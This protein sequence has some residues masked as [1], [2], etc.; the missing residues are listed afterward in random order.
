MCGIAGYLC[1]DPQQQ[2]SELL[3][4]RMALKLHHRGPDNQGSWASGPVALGHA[5]LSILD[6]RPEANQPMHHESGRFVVVFNGE[7]YNFQQLARSHGLQMRTRCDTEV[8]LKLYQRLGVDFL[9]ELRGMF[10]IALWDAERR[11]LLLARDRLGKKPLYYYLGSRG[12]SFASEVR[13]LLEDPGLSPQVDLEGIHHYLSLGF[14]PS[15]RSAFAGVEKV[16]PG[17][18]VRFSYGA[19]SSAPP[20]LEREQRRY[21]SLQFREPRRASA[22]ALADELRQTLSEAV[23][24]RMISDVPLGAF[25]SGGLDSSSIVALMTEHSTRP[26]KTFSIGFADYEKSELAHARAVAQHFGTEHHEEVVS[27]QAAELLPTLVEHYGE[28]FADPSAVPTYCLCRLTREH[29]T[30]ALSG[31]GA[32]ELFAGYTRYAHERLARI[33]QRL[34]RPLAGAISGTLGALPVPKRQGQLSELLALVRERAVQLQLPDETRF[35]SQYGNIYTPLLRQLYTPQMHERTRVDAEAFIGALMRGSSARNPVDRLLEVDIKGYLACD[36]FV[37][38]DI[39]SMA[40]SLE[41][42]CPLV[43]QEVVALAEALR[44]SL[45]LCGFRG[46][47]LLRRAMAKSLPP[48]I[49]RR[50]KQGFGIPHAR[51]LRQDLREL[52]YDLLLSPRAL[53]RGYFERHALETLLDEHNRGLLDHGLR[54]WNL[55]WLELWHRRFIDRPAEARDA[56]AAR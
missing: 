18:Y 19:A 42:R 40:H 25:L 27:P 31:D 28:P 39:A 52:S 51:W 21:W 45:K 46:K 10:A 36:I 38:V 33:Y 14:I 9:K 30:V 3:V 44:P 29:V 1:R 15:D 53:G 22:N 6:L 49:A 41:V 26:V 17:G 24:L 47:Q 55:L 34:P 35:L 48:P 56:V 2:A 37:K 20:T 5:R 8:L 12:L 50:R 7:I 23:R 11:Q 43:D 16:A 4:R 13:A 32:D 54:I